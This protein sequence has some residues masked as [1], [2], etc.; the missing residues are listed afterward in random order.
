[1]SRSKA[2]SSKLAGEQS[3]SAGSHSP[4]GGKSLR[5][6]SPLE[7]QKGQ[8]DITSNDQI[9]TSNPHAKIVQAFSRP[10]VLQMIPTTQDTVA[11]WVPMINQGFTAVNRDAIRDYLLVNGTGDVVLNDTHEFEVD[12]TEWQIYG[13]RIDII[14]AHA[15]HDGAPTPHIHYMLKRKVQE[16]YQPQGVNTAF[17]VTEAELMAFIAGG[18]EDIG[19]AFYERIAQSATVQNRIAQVIANLQPAA[20]IEEDVEDLGGFFD[21]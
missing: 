18:Q 21:M 1:M 8:A 19:G 6:V 10:G 9:I 12:G 5:A 13:Y 7:N 17:A 15:E 16:V 11:H 14:Q 3:K 2:S 4:L 20:A